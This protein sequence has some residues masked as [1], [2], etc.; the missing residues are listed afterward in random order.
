MNQLIKV[1]K[2]CNVEKIVSDFRGC[3][4]TCK[5]CISKYNY[6]KYKDKFKEYYKD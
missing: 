2:V 1:C 5:K 6:N 3:N 4:R